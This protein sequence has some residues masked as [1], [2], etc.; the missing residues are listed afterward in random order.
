LKLKNLIRRNKA[1]LDS[2]GNYLPNGQASKSGM[3]KSW[4]D[5][6]HGQFIQILEWL[7]IDTLRP[8]E[9]RFFIQ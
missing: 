4:L 2:D 3:N 7:A 1:K 8:E 5:A 9:R 6:G